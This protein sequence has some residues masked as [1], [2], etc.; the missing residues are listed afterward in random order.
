MNFRMWKMNFMSVN[1]RDVNDSGIRED[2][3]A[4]V[5]SRLL[6]CAVDHMC[7]HTVQTHQVDNELLHHSVP[8]FF[9]DS[10][11]ILPKRF[12]GGNCVVHNSGFLVSNH[13]FRLLSGIAAWRSNEV[14]WIAAT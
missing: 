11:N 4:D 14:A 13:V 2:A 5:L 3:F 7:D 9:F 1:L 6:V 10:R 8:P 12:N